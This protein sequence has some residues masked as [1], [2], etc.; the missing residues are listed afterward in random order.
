M[1][2]AGQ[3]PVTGFA[4]VNGVNIYWESRGSGGTPLVLL[5]GGYGLTGT[6]DTLAELPAIIADFTS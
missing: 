2:Q 3:Q 6:F 1:T 5:H 4:P